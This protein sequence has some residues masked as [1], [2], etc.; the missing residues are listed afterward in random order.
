M[1]GR[2]AIA[3]A[4]KKARTQ[5]RSLKLQHRL[6]ALFYLANGGNATAAYNEVYGL[7]KRQPQTTHVNASKLLSSAKVQAF[8]RERG[9]KVLQ[10]A[11]ATAD[12]AMAVITR[13][14]RL[15]P[16]RVLDPNT[17]K[18]LPMQDWPDDVALVVKVIKAN[19]DVVFYDKLQAATLIA[20]SHGKIKKKLDITLGFDHVRYLADKSRPKP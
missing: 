10:A 11:E 6:F 15:D 20:E 4:V 1:T 12:E 9:E 17:G 2:Q 3:K 7:G 18:M 19:G 16:R 14:L 5:G 13:T 8:I